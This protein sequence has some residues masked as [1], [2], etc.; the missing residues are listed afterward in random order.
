MS[1]PQITIT[2]QRDRGKDGLLLTTVS[3]EDANPKSIFVPWNL[4]S[5]SDSS[6]APAS[7]ASLEIGFQMIRELTLRVE[8]LEN[9]DLDRRLSLREHD[10]T[11]FNDRLRELESRLPVLDLVAAQRNELSADLTRA[12]ASIER[13][14][15]DR[16]EARLDS[17]SLQSRIQQLTDD[18]KEADATIARLMQEGT[19]ER[20]P[21][22]DDSAPEEPASQA[23]RDAIRARLRIAAMGSFGVTALSDADFEN[24]IDPRA[25]Q[26]GHTFIGRSGQ[27][28]RIEHVDIG[29]VNYHWRIIE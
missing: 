10:S 22:K 13:I 26:V 18:L 9:R 5:D 2:L 16:D 17:K 27:R 11:E 28:Y 8:E 7:H 12:N 25:L 21:V 24:G 29:I 23:S 15:C 1:E 3:G 6:P 4:S 19:R 20:D 14:A